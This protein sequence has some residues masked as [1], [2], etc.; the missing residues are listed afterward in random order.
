MVFFEFLNFITETRFSSSSF[1]AF[2]EHQWQLH[3][4]VIVVN[5][6][7]NCQTYSNTT[8]EAR[9]RCFCKFI[10]D[11]VWYFQ[12]FSSCTVFL[13]VKII[14]FYMQL[15]IGCSCLFYVGFFLCCYCVRLCN[16]DSN[17]IL[18]VPVLYKWSRG[19]WI[20]DDSS[21]NS[22]AKNETCDRIVTCDESEWNELLEFYLQIHE[23]M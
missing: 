5:Y 2:E 6:Y 17:F 14:S 11:K 13:V 4:F 12:Y 8:G 16:V 21:T 22:C 3:I 1:M 7:C 23:I 20:S 15:P 19:V 10:R 18:G 9:E